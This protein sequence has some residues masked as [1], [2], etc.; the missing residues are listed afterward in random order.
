MNHFVNKVFCGDALK[1]LRVLP[2][3]SV[4]AV[5]TDPMYGTSK[6]CIY[7]WGPDPAQSDPEKHWF[8]HQPMYEECRRVLKRGGALAWAQGVEFEDYYD[9]WFGKGH[10][11]WTLLRRIGQRVSG[12]LWIV[13]TREQQPIDLSRSGLI[14]CAPM[15]LLKKLGHPCIKPVEEMIFMIDTLTRPGNIV[16][17]CFSG[18]G[19]TLL[20]AEKLGRRWIGCDLSRRYCQV[21]MKRLAELSQDEVA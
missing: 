10:R 11:E 14:R 1:L 20:A 15:G 21:A 19:A 2:T 6:N 5:I 7:D 16:L 9:Q 4:D 12:H 17:D 3:A 13:Q 18:L 8:Y